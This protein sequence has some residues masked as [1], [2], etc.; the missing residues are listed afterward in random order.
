VEICVAKG[1]SRERE[2][3]TCCSL[4]SL[5]RLPGRFHSL[6]P[7]I[8]SSVAASALAWPVPLSLSLSPGKTRSLRRSRL[9]Q[10]G[11]K[12]YYNDDVWESHAYTLPRCAD[13]PPLALVRDPLPSPPS[14]SYGRSDIVGFAAW[15]ERERARAPVKASL[16]GTGRRRATILLSREKGERRR[17][18]SKPAKSAQRRRR[19]RRRRH[20]RARVSWKNEMPR[21]E[22]KEGRRK[23]RARGNSGKE[24]E[25]AFGAEKGCYCP[26]ICSSPSLSLPRRAFLFLVPLGCNVGE[27]GN[28]LERLFRLP[29]LC[30]P[31]PEARTLPHSHTR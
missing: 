2:R 26:A 23:G 22:G 10:F 6:S 15:R 19:H 18:G 17:A 27:K 4:L 20:S 8:N 12:A 29:V 7:L 9:R 24:E 14:S 25:K 13:R 16:R 3:A 30:I 28:S 5:L 21:R 31:C 1:P 11:L